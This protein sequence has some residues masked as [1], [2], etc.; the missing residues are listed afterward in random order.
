M[1]GM[2]Q[3]DRSFIQS[4]QDHQSDTYIRFGSFEVQVDHIY[5]EPQTKL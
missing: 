2:L 3:K 4:E 5:R 1:V